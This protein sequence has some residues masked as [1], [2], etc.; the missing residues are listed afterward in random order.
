M[1]DDDRHTN[2][3]VVVIFIHLG[4]FTEASDTSRDDQKAACKRPRSVQASL[5]ALRWVSGA[6]LRLRTSHNVLFTPTPPSSASASNGPSAQPSGTKRW[7]TGACLCHG[8]S[9]ARCASC[10]NLPW[11][12]T[13]QI[14]LQSPPQCLLW[15]TH[16]SQVWAP[17]VVHVRLEIEGALSVGGI[18]EKV[19]ESQPQPQRQP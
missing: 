19:R 6:G 18:S 13:S 8:L 10:R 9:M 15:K 4:E 12:C 7:S 2:L 5:A 11:V 3:V 1:C 14:R 17:V 16:V